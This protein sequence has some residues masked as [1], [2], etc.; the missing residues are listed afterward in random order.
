MGDKDFQIPPDL[1]SGYERAAQA[2][3]Q[4][5]LLPAISMIAVIALGV[6]LGIWLY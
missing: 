6:Y 2:P 4:S 5:A 1:S 3:R